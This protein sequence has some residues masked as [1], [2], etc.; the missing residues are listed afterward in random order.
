MGRTRRLEPMDRVKELGDAS[1]PFVFDVH[2]AMVF[3][4]DAP[5][6][7]RALHQAFHISGLTSLMNGKSS[8]ILR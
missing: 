7:E 2:H 4:E 6:L 3:S 1:V 8:S 5:S